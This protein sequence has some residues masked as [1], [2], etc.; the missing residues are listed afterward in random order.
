MKWFAPVNLVADQ[1]NYPVYRS[2]FAGPVLL[3]IGGWAAV[4]AGL[5]A[6]WR[7]RPYLLFLALSAL[8]LISPTSSIAPLAEMLNEHRPY[9]P[10]ALFSLC[11]MI[12]LGSLAVRAVRDR[13]PA[14]MLAI[15]GAV[16][17]LLGLGSMTF[18]R[19]LVFATDRSYL[20]DI[21]AKA[22]SGRALNNYGL[23]FMSEGNYDRALELFQEALEY[24]PNWHIVHIN[25]GIVYDHFNDPAN[26]EKEFDRAVE[27]DIYTGESLSFRGEFYLGQGRYQ[28][29][30]RDLQ[31]SRPKSLQHY[32]NAK[33]LATA[34]AGLG[35]VEKSLEETRHCLELDPGQ[36]AIDIVTIAKPFFD[37]SNLTRA[38]L[39]YFEQLDQSIPNT[40]WVH[41][42]ISTLA[43]RIGDTARAD[44]ARARSEEL[45]N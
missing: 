45:K 38:G 9:L 6:T 4:A 34:Y 10:L 12:P 36:T 28:E 35:D 24:T 8:A 19:N 27:S 7:T 14:R 21:I 15:A 40:W 3:A 23:T 30:A 41:A 44:A 25:L 22:P 2:L 33:G 31:A 37:S 1:G 11:W 32:R 42:N 20:E 5:V 18:Q 43:S 13:P 16:M 29:A 26:A 39:S 17:L